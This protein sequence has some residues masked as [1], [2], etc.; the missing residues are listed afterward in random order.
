MPRG[1]ETAKL[2]KPDSHGESQGAPFKRSGSSSPSSRF[3][4][5]CEPEFANTWKL[6]TRRGISDRGP[7][8]CQCTVCGTV[9]PRA[10]HGDSAVA[11]PVAIIQSQYSSLG[12]ESFALARGKAH[13]KLLST[14]QVSEFPWSFLQRIC[15][16][17]GAQL[18]LPPT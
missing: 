18:V 3:C 6:A 8:R 7:G 13:G 16:M 2:L 1:P 4:S 12:G 14:A 17:K 15:S 9:R 5:A 11:S 10:L